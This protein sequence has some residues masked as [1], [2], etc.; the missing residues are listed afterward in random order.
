V[1]VTVTSSGPGVSEVSVLFAEEE[2]GAEATEGSEATAPNPILP[3][4]PELIWGAGTFIVL[5]L[6]MRY[7][8]YPRLQRGTDARA[9]LIRQGNEGAEQTRA[10]IRQLQANYDAG[11]AGARAEAAAIID[12]ARAEVE[13]DRR[14][15]LEAAN[16][17]ISALKADAA[18]ADD[19]SR[20]AA[21]SGV[22][23]AVADVAA[24][25]AG[26]ALGRSVDPAELRPLAADVVSGGAR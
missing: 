9:E 26:R 18:A 1:R 19:A 4:G 25:L 15:K 11:I 5:A 7:F 21:L 17:R 3:V 8:L 23:D 22:E 10:D 20:S 6:L 16:A 2:E 13:A 12:A 14:Q 24:V